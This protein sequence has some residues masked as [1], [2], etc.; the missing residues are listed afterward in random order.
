[1]YLVI[2]VS[3]QSATEIES[4]AGV[5]CECLLESEGMAMWAKKLDQLVP[6]SKLV[7]LGGRAS[8]STEQDKAN[9]LS[10]RFFAKKKKKKKKN[11]TLKRQILQCKYCSRTPTKFYLFLL[12]SY[13]SGSVNFVNKVKSQV[14][15][16]TAIR[17]DGGHEYMIKS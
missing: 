2:I 8:F 15:I 13:G 4:Q 3:F 11:C 1:M 6:R 9:Y 12:K 17:I 16:A 7:L 5:R 14:L 10:T